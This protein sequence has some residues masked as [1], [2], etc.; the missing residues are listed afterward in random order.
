[1][2]E[3]ERERERKIEGKGKE[4]AEGGRNFLETE[5][6]NESK[7][8]KRTKMPFRFSRARHLP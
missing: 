5:F 1:M 6:T 4:G 8:K 7:K 3:R 2:R